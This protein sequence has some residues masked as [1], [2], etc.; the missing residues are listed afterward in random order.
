MSYIPVYRLKIFEDV[1]VLLNCL[2]L[3]KINIW[4]ASFIHVWSSFEIMCI[5]FIILLLKTLNYFTYYSFFFLFVYILKYSLTQ[6]CWNAWWQSNVWKVE[7]SHSRFL[8]LLY[9]LKNWITYSSEVL[10]LHLTNILI[11]GWIQFILS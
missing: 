1:L 3:Y 6:T 9:N 2:N 10:S 8:Y 5:T 11:L 4:Y 7:W